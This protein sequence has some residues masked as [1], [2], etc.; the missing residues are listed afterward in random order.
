MSYAP[1]PYLNSALD[2]PPVPPVAEDPQQNAQQPTDQNAQN[3]MPGDAYAATVAQIESAGRSAAQNSKSSA[4][5]LYGF[6]DGT[7]NDTIKN[8]GLD[9]KATRAAHATPEEQRKVLDALTA[10]NSK[11]YA[12]LTGNMTPDDTDLYG[13]HFLGP[14]GYAN[15]ATADPSTPASAVLS[16]AAIAA[17]PQLAQAKTAGDVMNMI[18]AKVTAA[19]GS[20]QAAAVPDSAANISDNSNGPQDPYM[21]QIL[22]SARNSTPQ[23]PS[24]PSGSPDSQQATPAPQGASTGLGGLLAKMLTPGLGSGGGILSQLLGGDGATSG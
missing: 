4:S 24:G 3:N 21:A 11:A 2:V 18:D 13:M 14:T 6:T 10:D 20:T 12:A 22:A 9:I 15:V 19:K 8:A 7:W 1:A 16:R 23:G 5:G 17:N